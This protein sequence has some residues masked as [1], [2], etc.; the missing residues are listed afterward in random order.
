[1]IFNDAI[2][3]FRPPWVDQADFS[4]PGARPVSLLIRGALIRL[5]FVRLEG[6]ESRL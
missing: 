3:F 2:G 6:T 4:A 1:M 5:A